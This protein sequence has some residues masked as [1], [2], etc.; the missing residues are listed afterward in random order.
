MLLVITA[1]GGKNPSTA[2]VEATVE[3]TA[4]VEPV[5]EATTT[6]TEITI[7]N[8][9]SED[10]CFLYISSPDTDEWGEEQLGSDFINA[11]ESYS[12]KI[13]PG[14]YDL[15]AE[16]CEINTLA[17]EYSVEITQNYVWTVVQEGATEPISG[18]TISIQIDNVSSSDVCFLYISPSD[19]GSWGEDVLGADLIFAGDSWTTEVAA[20]TYD[21]LAEDCDNEELISVMGISESYV[22]T[23]E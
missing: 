9:T 20:G 10:I 1:C 14:T 2:T 8:T 11:G 17:E 6:D 21:I 22:L 23:V 7:N 18:E 16:D 3:A 13:E 15:L 5:T 12:L 19:A 4:E